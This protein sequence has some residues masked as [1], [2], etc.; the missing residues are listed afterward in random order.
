MDGRNWEILR[1]FNDKRVDRLMLLS[2]IFVLDEIVNFGLLQLMSNWSS[3]VTMF[4]KTS[5]MMKDSLYPQV[6][7]SETQ[8]DFGTIK[9][10]AR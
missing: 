2:K 5:R 4:P 8:H 10:Q 7:V 3:F 1:V 9:E 6:S